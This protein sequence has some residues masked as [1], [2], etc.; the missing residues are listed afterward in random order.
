MTDF[1]MFRSLYS[2]SLSRLLL[3]SNRDFY[4]F[5]SLFTFSFVG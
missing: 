1:C 4:L 2:L 5:T 3:Y